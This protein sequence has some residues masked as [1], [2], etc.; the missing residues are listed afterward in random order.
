MN[1]IERTLLDGAL[2]SVKTLVLHGLVS[3]EAEVRG[4]LTEIR[5][6]CES[7][8][9][10]EAEGSR[11]APEL[12]AAVRERLARQAT[13]LLL[14]PQRVSE[15]AREVLGELNTGVLKLDPDAPEKLEEGVRVVALSQE[16]ELSEETTRLFGLQISGMRVI[17]EQ[18][19]A[20]RRAEEELKVAQARA[21]ESSRRYGLV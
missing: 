16:Q 17:E 2:K 8:S 3:V 21:R 9:L 10:R 6:G 5:G 13:L 14:L 7:L 4:A 19:A 15:A 12:R 18:R 20:V 1:P 11:G